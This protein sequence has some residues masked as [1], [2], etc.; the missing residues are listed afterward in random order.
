MGA[1]E[2]RLYLLVQE[3]SRHI[4]QGQLARL[5][6]D[7]TRPMMPISLSPHLWH[8]ILQT[9]LPKKKKPQKL[10]FR[11]RL[12]TFGPEGPEGTKPST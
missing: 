7:G 8:S 4:R 6:L 12:S 3:I 9:C 1:Q 10:D 5:R 2:L 11:I